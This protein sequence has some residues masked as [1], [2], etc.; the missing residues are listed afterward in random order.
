MAITI[1]IAPALLAD[2]AGRCIIY[3]LP[4]KTSNARDEYRRDPS[5]FKRVGIMNSEGRLVC[6]DVGYQ[7]L[8][9]CEPLAAGM[10]LQLEEVAVQA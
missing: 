10:Q 3:S 4:R 9:D 2:V 5:Q 8:K 6:C 1:Y 7:E